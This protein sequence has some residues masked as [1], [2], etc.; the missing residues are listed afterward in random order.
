MSSSSERGTVTRGRVLRLRDEPSGVRVAHLDHDLT[1]VSMRTFDPDRIEAACEDGHRAGFERGR[2]EGFAAALAEG[3]KAAS[4][5][6]EVTRRHL[7]AVLLALRD[8]LHKVAHVEQVLLVATEDAIAEAGL[9]LAEAVLGREVAASADPGREAIAR[10]LALAPTGLATARVLLH[11]DDLAGLGSLDDI[12][13][14]DDVELIG[15]DSIERGGCV[16][17]SGDC[18]IDAQLGP[19]LRRALAVLVDDLEEGEGS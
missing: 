5:E 13:L 7:G 17:E 15:D 4:G 18:T 9:R 14:G 3:R 1:E 19:A 12:A 2:S 6:L 8:Q 11:P 16:L 10:A